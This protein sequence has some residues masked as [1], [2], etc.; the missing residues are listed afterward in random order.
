MTATLGRRTTSIRSRPHAASTPISRAPTRVP[1]RSNVSPRA[2]SEPA[3]ETNCPGVAT[4]RSSIRGW[5]S[6]ISSVCSIITT[7]SAPRGMTPPVAIA[8][9]VPGTTVNA[10][11]W[12]Q[13]MTSALS[14]KVLGMASLAPTVSAARRANPSTFERSNGGASTGAITSPQRTRVRASASVIDS[15]GSGAR[16]RWRSKRTRASSGDTTSRNCSCRAA[17]RTRA[18]RSPSSTARGFLVSLIAR[19]SWQSWHSWPRPYPNGRAGGISFAVRRDHDPSVGAGK[20]RQR[21]ILDGHGLHLTGG[22]PDRHDFRQPDGRT[23]LARQRQ[24]FAHFVLPPPG[25][26]K[27]IEQSSPHHEPCADRGIE[28]SRQQQDRSGTDEAE[29]G[30]LPWGE[31]EAVHPKLSLSRENLHAVVIAPA[32]RSTDRDNCIRGIGGHGNVETASTLVQPCR[33]AA[34]I[35][36]CCNHPRRSVDDPAAANRQNANARFTHLNARDTRCGKSCEVRAAQALAGTAQGDYRIAIASCRQ[37][38]V[39][40]TDREKGLGTT[41]AHFHRVKWRN[42]VSSCWQSLPGFDARGHPQQRRRRMTAGTQCLVRI[43][44]PSIMQCQRGRRARWS[45]SIGG[46]RA[47]RTGKYVDRPLDDRLYLGVDHQQ[48]VGERRQPRNGLYCLGHRHC[49]LDLV[50]P[51]DFSLAQQREAMQRWLSIGEPGRRARVYHNKRQGSSHD[52]HRGPAPPALVHREPSRHSPFARLL[53]PCLSRAAFRL[54]R[55]PRR[56]SASRGNRHIRG[57]RHA[58]R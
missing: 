38:T 16:S 23:D 46:Q 53:A 30:S 52:D 58:S 25:G 49:L 11:T 9:H 55:L 54:S 47:S 33:A 14:V 48:N 24:G 35:D 39:T 22:V 2:I 28:T 20:R 8:V 29:R 45:H 44:C 17:A 40:G 19:H 34:S 10:G 37:D 5:P 42:T 36:V 21:K 41:L 50:T 6:S 56:S 13:A 51:D 18:I 3:Y 4:R 31:G 57:W 7:A 43:D 15:P 32:A 26:G 27:P 12:P 1:R